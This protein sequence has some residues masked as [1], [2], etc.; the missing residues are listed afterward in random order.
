MATRVENQ[1]AESTGIAVERLQEIKRRRSLDD[2][3]LPEVP[4][5]ALIRL[6]ERLELPD[7]PLAR[8][9]YLALRYRDAEGR[10]PEPKQIWQAKSEA[11]ELRNLVE[12]RM[13]A[14]IPTG[15]AMA[16][17]SEEG[18]AMAKAAK[19]VWKEAGPGNIGGRT[20]SIVP[21]PTTPDLLYAGSVGGGVWRSVDNGQSWHP[22]GDGMANMAVCSM[23][24]APD[25]ALFA[26]TGEGFGNADALRG[27]GIFISPGGT[28]WFQLQ[29]TLTTDFQW[30]NR[31]A[32]LNDPSGYVILAATLSGM[33][34]SSDQG[35]TWTKQLVASL[36][37]AKAH[38]TDPSKA[39]AATNNGRAYYT[40]DGGLTWTRAQPNPNWG[41]GR[42]ELAYATANPDIVYASVN[43]NSGEI[44][45]STDGG[46]T[47]TKRASHTSGGAAANYLG[48]QGW[49]DNV[50]W[51]GVPNDPDFVMVGGIDLWRSTDGGD[52]LTR[53][54][55]WWLWNSGSVHA[56]HHVIVPSRGFDGVNNKAVYF[57]ND[58]GIYRADNVLTAGTPTTTTGWSK[59]NN[60]Y[61]V[62]QFYYGAGNNGSGQIVAGA[63]DNGTLT[64]TTATGQNW[65]NLFG[66]DGG[67]CGADQNDNKTFYGEYV[68]LQIFRSTDT[69]N[70]GSYIWGQGKPAPYLLSDA[71]SGATSLFISPFKV[72]PNQTQRILAGGTSL[73]RTNDAKAAITGATGPSW[74][75]IKASSA[76][77]GRISAIAIAPSSS[78]VVMVGYQWGQVWHSTN[79]TNATPTWTRNGPSGVPY[80][81]SVCVDPTNTDIR[82]ATFGGYGGSSVWRYSSANTPNWNNITPQNFRVP[83]HSIAV[84]PAHNNW[85]YIG[86]DSGLWVSDDSGATWEAGN[87]APT[88]C[89]IFDLFWMGETLVIVTHGRGVFTVDLS[90]TPDPSV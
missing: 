28:R 57:G 4:P 23:A 75:N 73:W 15:P 12:P 21:H 39:V 59:L 67:A 64:T 68:Y 46:Q 55:S 83:V 14:G 31:L 85:L 27:A 63:Q 62:T 35:Q 38:P 26:G 40:D 10:L 53:I 20:R 24:V 76:A 48:G 52:T 77:S 69:A 16:D 25:G 3:V 49:Y 34:R 86:T 1:V 42:V 82:Y 56:D 44:W 2:E 61:A 81:T 17:I 7:M 37:D 18:I 70:S 90:A 84:H 8:E 45:K 79:A 66:G 47:F 36:T 74:E 9:D 29:S 78:D 54:S 51:A 89:A 41:A 43:Q 11:M 13:V 22:L 71:G 19:P 72:D 88:N 60:E 65:Y 6:N 33:M 87:A 80:C 50:I 58:G 5:E 32:I 30:V